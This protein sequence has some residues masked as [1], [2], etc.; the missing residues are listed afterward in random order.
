[1]DLF[2]SNILDEKFVLSLELLTYVKDNTR[3]F[4]KMTEKITK[5]RYVNQ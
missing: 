2:V 1:M 4:K 5:V 3:I